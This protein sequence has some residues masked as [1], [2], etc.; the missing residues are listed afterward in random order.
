MAAFISLPRRNIR[1]TILDSLAK[2]FRNH[3]PRHL[4]KPCLK[5]RENWHR[6][7]SRPTDLSGPQ[8]FQIFPTT[9]KRLPYM[10]RDDPAHTIDAILW[11][12][13]KES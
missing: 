11:V 10:R 7:A 13:L 12:T 3:T 9:T 8:T 2:P 1:R 4:I 6:K 5:F